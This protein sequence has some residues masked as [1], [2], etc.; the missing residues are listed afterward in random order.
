MRHLRSDSIDLCS[1]YM[2]LGT[3]DNLCELDGSV[4][5][6][7]AFTGSG[8]AAAMEERAYVVKRLLLQQQWDS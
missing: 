7:N 5:S 3:G 2:Y 8:A 6:G 1:M 4:F